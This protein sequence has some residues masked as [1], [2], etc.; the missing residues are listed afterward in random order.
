MNRALRL[1]PLLLLSA[2]VAPTDSIGEGSSPIY[3]GTPESGYPEVV[4]LYNI[5]GGACTATIVAPRLVLTAKHCVQGRGNFASPASEFR[6]Y[7]GSSAT[8]AT[9]Q[10]RVQEVRPVPGAWDLSD[11]SDVAVL[12]LSS[13]A[14]ET[15]REMTFENPGVLTG[16]TF[17]AVGYGERENGA[18]GAKY[19]TTGRVQGLR[20]NFIFVEP[21]ICSGDSGGPMIGAE[22]KIWGVVSFGYNPEG[23]RQVMCGDP[24]AYNAIAP[25]Q[26]FI[27]Q[28]LED[29]GA[30]VESEEICD[31][32]DNDCDGELDEGC[33]P[34]GSN[35]S[36][37]DECV[38]QRCE[39]VEPSGSTVC[40]EEC[41]P[42]RP[43]L[44]CPSGFFCS[45]GGLGVC[46]GLCAPGSIGTA[47]VDEP[48]S[49]NADCL[50]GNCVDPGDG[51][52]RCLAFCRGDSG[53][54][55]AGEV[56]VASAT[57]CGACVPDDIF[58]GPYGIGEPCRRDDQCFSGYCFTDAGVSYCSRE[59]TD[60][61]ACGEGF[62]CRGMSC[63]R[64]PRESVGGG[65]ITNEDCASGFCA[66][67]DGR[68]WCSEFCIADDECPMGFAC[69]AVDATTNVCA[70]SVGLVGDRCSDNVDC[71]SGLCAM[72]TRA[73]SVCTEQC[74]PGN[75]CSPGFDCVRIDG[76]AV[77]ICL[78]PS[79]GGGCAAGGQGGT[80]F[81]F[82]LGAFALI[83]TRRR[84]RR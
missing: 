51:D 1:L 20:R 19:M 48:C 46:E 54:C 38:G 36:T 37:D 72:G 63:V 6:V 32:V 80:G 10:Y 33:T 83:V 43:E 25:F 16:T 15:P 3:M 65:C 49:S 61:T 24:G 41:D 82:V 45:S 34:I 30:C 81:A 5:R 79:E 42:L 22:G 12:I 44:G 56:C 70:P 17:T 21:T 68:S 39:V 77:A 52:Q 50:I 26:A 57:S 29:S 11:G 4:F 76:G 59:C 14:D 18:S 31:G 8:A 66:S 2:C 53:D 28:A 13:A 64:G 23:G 78:P 75:A 58:A 27:E 69:T 7:V 73:G 9:K 40:T 35:C 55:L 60:D 47:L 67:S 84:R 71:A 62:H 74:G